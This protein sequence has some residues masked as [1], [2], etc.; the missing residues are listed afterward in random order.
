MARFVQ[1]F[2][3]LEGSLLKHSLDKLTKDPHFAQKNQI[4]DI[5]TKNKNTEYGQKYNFAKINNEKDFQKYVPINKYQDLE[6]YIEKTIKGHSNILT[7]DAP[8]MFN[9]TSGTSN[10]PKYIPVTAKTKKGIDILMHH[11]LYRSLL[12]HPSF[13]DKFILLITSPPIE[14][15]TALGIPYGS[16][17]GQIYNNLP[18][19]IMDRYALPFIVAEIKNY[20]LRYYA[21]ARLAFEKDVSFIATPNPTTLIRLAEVGIQYQEEIV[22][23]IQDGCL[24]T[25]SNFSIN[26]HDSEI[27]KLLN[28]SRKP[29]RTRGKVLSN[30]IK[31]NNRLLPCYCWPSI[32]LIGCWLG[33]SVGYHAEKLSTYYGDIPQRDIGYL[34]SEG[35]ITLPYEDSTASG[36]LALQNNYYE[37]VLEDS[38]STSHHSQ[39]LLSHELEK[40]KLYKVLLTNESGLY[41]Y[42]INDI[43]RVEKFYNQTPVLAFVHKTS[44]FINITGEK[45]HLNQLLMTFKKV[46]SKFDISISQFRVTSNY[47]LVRHEI[48]MAFSQDVSLELLKNSVLPAIDLYL[49]EINIEYSQKRKSKRLN[50]PCLHV[51]VSSWEKNIKK[52]LIES[53]MRDIQYKWQPISSDFIEMDKKYVE[54]TIDYREQ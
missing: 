43:V 33:G 12:D 24:F 1:S 49:S 28:N 2:I 30:V 46:Q 26:D 48:F 21:M 35:S 34:A 17:S 45:I 7:T 41:R 6:P 25:E 53:G 9:L 18:R 22:R 54:Y 47:D 38:D 8:V 29:N 50:S 51:M 3:K 31:N 15:Y 32:K 10:K 27:I 42:D 11:W 19:S 4:L 36:L 23:S 52:N 16:L 5:L 14:G 20:D 44:D 13:L 40:D 37:F 39:V